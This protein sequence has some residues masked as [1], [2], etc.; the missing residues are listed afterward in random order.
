MRIME[1]LKD[2]INNFRIDKE[3]VSKDI[4]SFTD[5]LGRQLY[6][7]NQLITAG[8][9]NSAIEN[10]ISVLEANLSP[11]LPKD[12]EN[13]IKQLEE[14]TAF[15]LRLLR[16]NERRMKEQ[17]IILRFLI[18][19]YSLLLKFSKEKGFLPKTLSWEY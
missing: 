5:V 17:P 16:S 3:S 19:K 7:I 10:G 1:E 15:K 12:Y 11:Y 4:E 6:M 14:E 9:Y 2:E 18:K 13:D 8:A